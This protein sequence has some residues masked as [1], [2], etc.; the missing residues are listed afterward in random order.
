[1]LSNS[2]SNVLHT[3][4]LI[5]SLLFPHSPQEFHLER[6]RIIIINNGPYLNIKNLNTPNENIKTYSGVIL[7]GSKDDSVEKES[8]ENK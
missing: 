6:I 5:L 8:I 1:M 4:L 3:L 7:A 2:S